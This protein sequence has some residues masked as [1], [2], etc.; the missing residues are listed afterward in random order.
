MCERTYF[1]F[2]YVWKSKKVIRKF[3]VGE[4]KFIFAN[5]PQLTV[6]RA[7]GF[8]TRVLEIVIEE[9]AKEGELWDDSALVKAFDDAV[10]KYKV[11]SISIS[12]RF[13]SI[14]C[15]DFNLELNSSSLLFRK[16]T[17]RTKTKL[18]FTL[19]TMRI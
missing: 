3:S 14:L 2:G 13:L 18:L 5:S 12:T 4:K 7:R 17:A 19:K 11:S 8:Y 15:D 16:C 6:K 10:S 9:M 1:R